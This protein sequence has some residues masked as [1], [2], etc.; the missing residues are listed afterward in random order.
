MNDLNEKDDHEEYKKRIRTLVDRLEKGDDF[1]VDKQPV[2][3]KSNISEENHIS[4]K[5]FKVNEDVTLKLEGE[6]FI[7]SVKNDKNSPFTSYRLLPPREVVRN[8]WKFVE[9][10]NNRNLDGF[11]IALLSK[12]SEYN[13]NLDPNELKFLLDWDEEEY[14]F[15]F[16]CFKMH[17]NLLSKQ[18]WESF[19]TEV[20]YGSGHPNPP[21][22]Y[23]YAFNP[24]LIRYTDLCYD[25]DG[26]QQTSIYN[27]HISG[28]DL[29]WVSEI[30]ESIGYLSKLKYLSIT[31]SEELT[32]L[33]NSFKN[34]RNLRH[35]YFYNTG[36]KKFPDVISSL[37]KLRSL[38]LQGIK[39][40]G[41]P[42]TVKKIGY[43]HHSREY[44][45]EGVNRN[46]ANVLGLLE[47]L[48]GQPFEKTIYDNEHADWYADCPVTRYD[49]E[50]DGHVS[51]LTFAEFSDRAIS[52]IPEEIKNLKN[53]YGLTIEK[54]WGPNEV[55]IPKSLEPF[56]KSLKYFRP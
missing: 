7:I 28:L 37:P 18:Y 55:T 3:S 8:I 36:I 13:F 43:K 33:P 1:E 2:A 54:Y 42:E 25:S 22:I 4:Y 40:D 20:F 16:P 41:I 14:E 39:L 51:G 6:N 56:L 10:S 38:G 23:W 24:T 17:Q 27:G 49:L 26:G 46:D 19:G 15:Q 44:I 35:L 9:K 21:K 11:L 31:D 45:K 50:D 29:R 52:Y 48:A 30:P 53:L 32:A 34:L 5:E 12:L 47:I